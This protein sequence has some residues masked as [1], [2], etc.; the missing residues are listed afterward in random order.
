MLTAFVRACLAPLLLFVLVTPA[1]ALTRRVVH[2]DGTPVAGAEVSILGSSG[3]AT[4]DSD[5]PFTWTPDPPVPF[6]VLAVTPGGNFMKPILVE[7]LAA[8]QA[9][10]LTV[11]SLVS[12]RITVSGAA[13]NI[14]ATPSAA[15]ASL[16]QAEIQT[17]L[18][19]NLVQAL[20]NVA[21]VN[22]VSEG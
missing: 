5:G 2:A 13:P 18:P 15:T 4:T 7:R 14:E 10:V 9:L 12:E 20:E 6:E 1:V 11:E 8:G 19:S 17:R 22:Q 21:G 3:T 16:S